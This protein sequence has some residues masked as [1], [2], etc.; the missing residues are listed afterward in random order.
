MNYQRQYEF[1]NTIW[2]KGA[3]KTKNLLNYLSKRNY[4]KIII[5]TRD[6]KSTEE[7]SSSLSLEEYKSS[8]FLDFISKQT[9]KSFSMPNLLVSKKDNYE[10]NLHESFKRCSSSSIIVSPFFEGL[11]L[12]QFDLVVFYDLPSI[13]QYM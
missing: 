6:K 5:I 9:F 12:F 13:K 7:L 10:S 11:R 3:H 8:N 1:D 2:L 4:S